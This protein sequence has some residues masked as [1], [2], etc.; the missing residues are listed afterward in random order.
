MEISVVNKI[1][2]GFFAGVLGTDSALIYPV[3]TS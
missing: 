3:N 2:K 1:E